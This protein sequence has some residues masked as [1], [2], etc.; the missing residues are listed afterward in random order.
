MKPGIDKEVRQLM[1]QRRHLRK[2]IKCE[3]ETN[4]K[5]ILIK[6]RKHIE[7]NIIRKV[8]ENEEKRLEEIT[9]KLNSKRDNNDTLW[10][11]KKKIERKVPCQCTIKDKDGNYLNDPM[12]I[13]KRITEHYKNLYTQN[14]IPDGY[15]E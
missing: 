5:N 11:L 7:E 9:D 6:E 13:K 1:E 3:P 4:A 8:E 12:K 14:D 10:K 2:R 15:Q